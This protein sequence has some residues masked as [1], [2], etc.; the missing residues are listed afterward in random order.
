MTNR[1]KEL[2]PIFA[3][4]WLT[5]LLFLGLIPSVLFF[6]WV[7]RNATLPILAR[8]L[9][10]PWLDGR[11]WP[12]ALQLGW[13]LAL[14]LGFGLGHSLLAQPSVKDRLFQWFPVQAH[15]SLY[16][17]STGLS[18]SLVAG[19]WQSTGVV[20]WSTPLPAETLLW[21]SPVLFWGLFTVGLSSLSGHGILRFFGFDSLFLSNQALQAEE[22]S[23]LVRTGLYRFVRHPLYTFTLAAFL[24]APVMTL[25]RFWLFSVCLLYLR[26]AIP[27]EEKK[28]VAQFGDAYRDY[29]KT[30]P[31]LLPSLIGFRETT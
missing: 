5:L 30:T 25:D 24:V 18:L 14:F 31:A 22:H 23:P 21:I 19:F 17:V 8:F 6:A 10:W 1:P 13:N 15:R 11:A 28:L 9:E 3:R 20:F 12:V 2:H 26:F 27:Q 4:L 16:I 29:Q 7:E